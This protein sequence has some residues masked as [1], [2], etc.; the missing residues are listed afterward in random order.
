MVEITIEEIAQDPLTYL[1]R[2]QIGESFVVLKAGK[3][4]AQINPVQA[5][6]KMTLA[7]AIAIVQEKMSIEELNT[8][9]DEAWDNVRDFTPMSDEPRW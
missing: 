8:D 9:S 7:N 5:N 1:D 6:P 2:T 4:I 3:A